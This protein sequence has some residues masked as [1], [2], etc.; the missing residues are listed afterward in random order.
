M[1]QD[2]P[3]FE[4]WSQNM[5]SSGLTHDPIIFLNVLVEEHVNKEIEM[6]E[7][8]ESQGGNPKDF[9]FKANAAFFANTLFGGFDDFD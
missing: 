1:I 9:D 7:R 8:Y 4:V 3:M 6:F 5:I 2:N